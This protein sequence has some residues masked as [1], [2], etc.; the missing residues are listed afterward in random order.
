MPRRPWDSED[1]AF[2]FL[3]RALAVAGT[4]IVIVAI[5]RVAF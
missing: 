4:V 3:L 2:L 5:I 1:E